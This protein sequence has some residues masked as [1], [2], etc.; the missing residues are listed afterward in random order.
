MTLRAAMGSTDSRLTER[1]RELIELVPD[2]RTRDVLAMLFFSR[3]ES[4]AQSPIIDPAS[5]VAE[6]RGGR[7]AWLAAC[8]HQWDR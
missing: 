5:A 6:L 8:A 3:Q 1:C 4:P 2:P 7:D